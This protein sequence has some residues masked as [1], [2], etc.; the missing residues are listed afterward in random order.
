MEV[1]HTVTEDKRPA[2]ERL[3][4]SL[5]AML[6]G[7]V[8]DEHGIAAGMR[9]RVGYT[10]FSLVMPNFNTLGRGQA[11]ADG[12]SWAPLSPAYL[13]YK[14]PITGR[15]PPRAGG[16]APGGHDGFL[17]PELLRL[18][19]RTYAECLAFYIF[20]E[21]EESAK[22]HSAAIAWI[23]VKRAGA[24]TK[25]KEFGS[26]VAGVDYQTLV[27]VGTLRSSL[28]PGELHEDKTSAAYRS[29]KEQRFE[30]DGSR[31]VVGTLVP[32]AKYHH[33]GKGRRRRRL[34]PERFPADWWQQINNQIVSGLVRIGEVLGG[35]AV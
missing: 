1:T 34:W 30:E 29:R 20:R 24:K 9:A 22:A 33:H 25:L 7:R 17:T 32:Y 14:R 11:G 31:V 2:I 4:R 23:T 3:I 15:R 12:D 5:P 6:A 19:R 28:M 18:W 16:L 10:F 35:S 8:R 27:D 26:R 21:S 13:A